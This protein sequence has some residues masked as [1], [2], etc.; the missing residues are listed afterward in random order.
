MSGL[1]ILHVDDEPDIR[2]I[3]KMSLRLDDELVTRS[4]GSG[5]EALAI[6][7][8]WHL[9]MILLD[10]V[11]P[12]MDGPKTL[13]CL[14]ENPQ[15]AGIPVIFMT[16]RALTHELDLFRSL[17]AVGVIAKPFD[18][19]TLA[20]SVRKYL[21][22]PR[23]PLERLRSCFLQRIENDAVTLAQLH[24]KL[25]VVTNALAVVTQI[26]QIAHALVESAYIYGL[27]EIGDAVSALDKAA[28]EAATAEI[29]GTIWSGAID[30]AL[31]HFLACGQNQIS[32]NTLPR[33]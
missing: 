26:K 8:N 33:R 12:L 7:L 1:H 15:T 28:N 10:V 3:V 11:M 30:F 6:A 13:A 27:P 23:N 20:A 22:L 2:D 14:C 16:A 32:S 9:D 19:M 5:K 24:C 29:N 25:D 18:P 21:S 17:G 4:C 31:D